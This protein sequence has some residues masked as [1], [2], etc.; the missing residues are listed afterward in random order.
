MSSQ[1]VV[2]FHEMKDGTKA[3][4]DLLA[5][6][7]NDYIQSLADRLL[8]AVQALNETLGGYQV[9]R[10]EHSLQSAT[11]AYRDGKDEEYVVACVLHDIG[12][13]LAPATHGAM[14]AAIL[15]PYISEKMVWIVK[16]HGLFQLYYYGHYRGKDRN[17]RDRYK[18]HPWYDDCIEFCEKYDQNCFHPDYDSLSLEFFEPMVRR[19]FSG[20]PR[21]E[22]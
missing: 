3:D 15:S 2:S 16:Y 12:D 1:Q 10:F 13:V 5:E 8:G 11:R 19:I 18:D 20:E 14:T 17:G 4:Y 21:F 7:E 6:Y 22:F 9:N